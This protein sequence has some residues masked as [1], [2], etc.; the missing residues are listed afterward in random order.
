M[1]VFA[2]QGVMG[3]TTRVACGDTAAALAAEILTS[4]GR[5]CKGLTVVVCPVA[6][7]SV[8]IAVGADPTQG[9]SA[10]GVTLAPNDSMRITGEYNIANFKHINA[11]N[12]KDAVLQIMPEY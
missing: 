5:S 8:R 11:T 1:K 9:A 4:N 3:A 2:I 6:N 7:E 12:G 10:V